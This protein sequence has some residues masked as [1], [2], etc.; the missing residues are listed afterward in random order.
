MTPYEIYIFTENDCKRTNQLSVN[1]TVINSADSAY[2]NVVG[3]LNNYGG[4]YIINIE[5]KIR[6]FVCT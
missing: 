2:Y 3:L 5:I 1:P 4:A 6:P